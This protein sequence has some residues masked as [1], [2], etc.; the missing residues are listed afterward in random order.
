MR[1]DSS[2]GIEP[3]G[4]PII[5]KPMLG[6]R[7]LGGSDMDEYNP[8]G[9]NLHISP[10]KWKTLMLQIPFVIIKGE[11]QLLNTTNNTH[12]IDKRSKKTCRVGCYSKVE[13]TKM[14]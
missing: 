12:I 13:N 4:A 2:N 10:I 6:V 11:Y 8:C 1:K 9:T 14:C 5:Q 3:I 7:K